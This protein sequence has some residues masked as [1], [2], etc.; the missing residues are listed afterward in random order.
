VNGNQ[1]RYLCNLFV[2]SGAIPF[3]FDRN[4]ADASTETDAAPRG[5]IVGV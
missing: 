1:F 5:G 3:V 2:R 4:E